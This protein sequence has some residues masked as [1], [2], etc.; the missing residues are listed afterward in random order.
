M[1]HAYKIDKEFFEA[2]SPEKNYVLGAFYAS[3]MPKEQKGIIFQSEKKDLVMLIHNLLGSEHSI[4]KASGANSWYFQ[5]KNVG[6]MRRWLNRNG[7]SLPR[8]ERVFPDIQEEVIDHFIRGY[9]DAQASYQMKGDLIMM[10]LGGITEFKH[11]LHEAL[12]K[13]AK[14]LRDEPTTTLRYGHSDCMR[15]RKF[16]YRDSTFRRRGIYLPE[17]EDMLESHY[18]V[19]RGGGPENRIQ[20]LSR[21]IKAAKVLTTG[22]F[23]KDLR[24]EVG[25]SASSSLRDALKAFTGKSPR[26]IRELSILH[27]AKQLLQEGNLRVAEVAKA[28]HCTESLLQRLFRENE[29]TTARKW[30]RNQR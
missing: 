28:C 1:G 27:K 16:I 8:R 15:I 25:Y 24:A 9:I 6:S 29:G 4:A 22:R 18:R 19:T 3:Y 2:R 13:Y 12:V 20:R 21:A 10:L 23:D 17:T 5:A 26:E 11:G 7:V 30:A 14:V